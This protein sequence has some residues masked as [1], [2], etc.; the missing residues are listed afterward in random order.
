MTPTQ[1]LVT[2]YMLCGYGLSNAQKSGYRIRDP[3]GR[4]IARVN[5]RTIRCLKRDKVLIRSVFTLMINPE[6]REKLLKTPTIRKIYEKINSD[7]EFHHP[8]KA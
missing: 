1:K 5:V 6:K 8:S 7:N 3:A 2:A 4:V